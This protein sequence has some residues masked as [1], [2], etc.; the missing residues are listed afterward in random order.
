MLAHFVYLAVES[1]EAP[2]LHSVEY[3]LQTKG[4]QLVFLPAVWDPR[5]VHDSGWRLLLSEYDGRVA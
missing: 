1:Y 3:Q 5:Y 2:N 4:E